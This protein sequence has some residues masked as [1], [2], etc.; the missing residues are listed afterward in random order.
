VPQPVMTP[1][2]AFA[3]MVG[4]RVNLSE[5]ATKRLVD[6]QSHVLRQLQ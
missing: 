5:F 2:M 6:A 4:M 3:G 1:P